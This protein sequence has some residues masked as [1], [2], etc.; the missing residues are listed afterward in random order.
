MSLTAALALAR[1]AGA[2]TLELLA[3]TRCAA[4]EG[5]APPRA[6]LCPSCWARVLPGDGAPLHG[7]GVRGRTAPLPV[8]SSGAYEGP[9]G[10]AVRAMK[11]ADRPDLAG[12]LGRQLGERVAAL[13]APAAPPNLVIPVPLHPLRLAERGYDQAVLLAR[14]V[15]RALDLPLAPRAIRRV[16]ATAQQA[17]QSAAARARNVAGAFRPDRPLPGARAV[18]V[19]DVLTTGAT[20]WDAADAL[21]EA[22][23]SVQL[24]AVVARAGR[25][26]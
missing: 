14:E 2:A 8:L 5:E 20:A 19:D 1:R 22:G 4:C 9:L 18:L 21:A 12:P 26:A 25:A 11:F 15:A 6:A 24:V 13:A 3:P 7:A 23:A 10:A 16:Q 17:R